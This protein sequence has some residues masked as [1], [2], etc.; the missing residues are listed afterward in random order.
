MK[1]N[2]QEE[3]TQIPTSNRMTYI[4]TQYYY[5]TYILLRLRGRLTVYELSTVDR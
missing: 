2:F 5:N 3:S 1:L 4:L